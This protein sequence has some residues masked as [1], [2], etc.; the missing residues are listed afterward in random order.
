MGGLL[1]EHECNMY[2]PRFL[3]SLVKLAK[4]L[5]D[6]PVYSDG[7]YKMTGI[8]A[9]SGG[10][11]EVTDNLVQDAVLNEYEKLGL[12]REIMLT[13]KGLEWCKENCD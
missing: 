1:T 7:V 11:K 8:N 3:C 6:N 5:I 2:R 12:K 4:G 13:V 10:E 9:F